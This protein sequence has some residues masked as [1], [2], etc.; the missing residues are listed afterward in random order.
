MGD[1]SRPS[2]FECRHK[3]SELPD[4]VGV[5]ETEAADVGDVDAT[6]VIGLHDEDAAG[7][8]AVDRRVGHDEVAGPEHGSRLVEVASGV[9]IGRQIRGLVVPEREA[10]GVGECTEIVGIVGHWLAL[11]A[12]HFDNAFGIDQAGAL[13][14]RVRHEVCGAIAMPGHV[15]DHILT[16]GMTDSTSVVPEAAAH[17]GRELESGMRQPHG[18]KPV[19]GLGAAPWK[20]VRSDIVGIGELLD[21]EKFPTTASSR[22]PHNAAR[23]PGH[24]CPRGSRT[25]RGPWPW[26]GHRFRHRRRWWCPTMRK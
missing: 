15:G 10:I 23:H 21:V 18:A 11:Q 7:D 1:V 26:S 3:A 16:D 5:G 8:G 9:D 19:L 25:L 20:L 12:G 24:R 14:H 6:L 2:T 4:S 13:A 22:L 17:V